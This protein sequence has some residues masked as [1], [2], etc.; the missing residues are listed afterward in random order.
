MCRPHPEWTLAEFLPMINHEWVCWH[1]S[2]F[3]LKKY[4]TSCQVPVLKHMS[5]RDCPS[6]NKM[7]ISIC[8]HCLTSW[9]WSCFLLLAFKRHWENTLTAGMVLTRSPP[10]SVSCIFILSY[11]H[12]HSSGFPG[13]LTGSLQ[14]F[15]KQP[16]ELSRTPQ[17]GR[18]P[19]ASAH[20]SGDQYPKYTK[21]SKNKDLRKQMTQF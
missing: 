15:R 12:S 14:Q 6:L 1:L 21:N 2:L 17:D 5:L 16:T 9:S 11:N 20:L 10:S 8:S 3:L 4:I 18:E 7:V 19:L 13:W